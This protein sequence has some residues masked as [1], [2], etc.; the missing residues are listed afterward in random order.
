MATTDEQIEAMRSMCRTLEEDALVKE[1]RV[2]DWGRFGNFSILIWPQQHDRS[3]TTR[4]K[5]LVRKALPKGA[6]L[7]EVFGPD[8]IRDYNPYSRTSKIV[9]YSRKFWAI[10]IDYQ[11]FCPETNSFDGPYQGASNGG[12]TVL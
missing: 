3:T 9:G 6:H 8:P 10:D 7:R 5:A 11:A 1:A 2:D 12:A 4:L